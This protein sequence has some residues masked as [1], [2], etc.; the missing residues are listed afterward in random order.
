MLRLSGI[1]KRFE[2]LPVL[3][4]LSLTLSRGEIVAL[5][6]P[7]GCGKTTLLNIISGLT[8]PDAGT[9]E[10]VDGRLSYMF[11]SARL[12]PWRTVEENIR[13]VREDAPAG[14]VRSLIAAVGLEG[15]ERYYPS[16]LSGG[17]ARRCA[18]ARAFHF[19]GEIFLMDEPFQGLDYGIRMEMLSMLLS[20]WQRERP[21]Q[22]AANYHPIKLRRICMEPLIKNLPHARPFPLK[23]QVGYE[24]GKV[25]SLTLAQR[26]GV[27]MTLFAFDAGEAISTHAAPGD[28][29]ATILEGTA[30]ITIDGVPHTLNAGEAVIM[31]AGIPHAVQ[32]VTPFKMYL[33]VAKQ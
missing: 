23:D 32:A 10:G 17:M 14:E 27:G 19:G 13:L 2:D 7:S 16:Q 18:L 28:A 5:I 22:T 30:Q 6:G 15:F 21:L 12:L 4:N 33:V 29:M 31:P 3:S 1:C 26:P 24:P 11:Q 20:I 25:V 8:A 9:V